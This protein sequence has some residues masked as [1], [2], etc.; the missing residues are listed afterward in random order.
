M[1][2]QQNAAMLWL[3]PP[4]AFATVVFWERPGVF[5]WLSLSHAGGGDARKVSGPGHSEQQ[6]WSLLDFPGIGT[7]S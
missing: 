3:D 5:L 4:A 7:G 2:L 1:L 6:V